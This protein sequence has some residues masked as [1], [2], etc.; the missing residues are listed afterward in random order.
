MAKSGIRLVKKPD[1]KKQFA[2]FRNETAKLLQPTIDRRVKEYNKV[3]SGWQSS[4]KPDFQGQVVVSPRRGIFLRVV[5]RNASTV[6]NKYGTTIRQLWDIWNKG[7]KPH[8]IRPRFATILRF[9]VGGEVIF[10]KLVKHP[11][12]KANKDQEKIDNRLAPRERKDIEK[13]GQRA[14]RRAKG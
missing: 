2:Q 3:T 6:F 1:P 9:V 12:T 4:H 5:M 11:G 13:V 8:L 10:T 7:S 14:L